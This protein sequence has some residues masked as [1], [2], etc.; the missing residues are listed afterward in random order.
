LFLKNSFYAKNFKNKILF[1]DVADALGT[2]S[3]KETLPDSH[4]LPAV[5][6]KKLV[7]IIKLK[8][9]F[10]QIWEEF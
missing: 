4:L 8:T 3:G 5:F 10:R 7:V 2:G 6:G 1:I 9:M